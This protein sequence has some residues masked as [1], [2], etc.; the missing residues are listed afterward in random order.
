MINFIGKSV[1]L[2]DFDGVIL[3]SM[4]VREYGFRKVLEKYPQE[5]VEELLN[6]HKEN[7]GLSRYVKF[8]YFFEEIRNED[9]KEEQLKSLTERYSEIMRAKLV[10]QKNLIPESVDFIKENYLDYTMHIVSG[11]DGEELRFLCNRLGIDKY[12]ETIN[13]SPTP[14]IELVANLVT[15]YSYKPKELCLIGDSKNDYEAAKE[16]HIDFYGYNNPSLKGL[17]NQYIN[18]FI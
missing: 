10:S 1:V 12:F 13:G 4:P 7:G 9:L 11:S 6:F 17:G 8:R 2:W 16:N 14:K 15:K 18:A 3:D 5:Q